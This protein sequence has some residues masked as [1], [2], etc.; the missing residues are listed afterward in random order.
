MKSSCI[1]LKCLTLA[2]LI[3]SMACE[4]TEPLQ[5]ETITPPSI[6]KLND[7]PPILNQMIAESKTVHSEIQQ[8]SRLLFPN[9]EEPEVAQRI[10]DDFKIPQCY[11]GSWEGIWYPIFPGDD[12]FYMTMELDGDYESPGAEGTWEIY[13]D[14]VVVLSGYLD[15]YAIVII[16][17]VAK[18]IYLKMYYQNGSY[19]NNG[20]WHATLNDECDSFDGVSKDGL[21][22]QGVFVFTR[23]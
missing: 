16:D 23:I 20:P 19:I 18:N 22:E 21:D 7:L 4:K 13:Y 14:G 1:I 6:S 3:L 9:P 2:L 10:P 17:G 15:V 8:N 5:P 11:A 12:V